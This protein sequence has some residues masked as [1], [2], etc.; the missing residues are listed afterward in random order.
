MRR[1]SLV[2]VVCALLVAVLVPVLCY[3]IYV[4]DALGKQYVSVSFLPVFH[5]YVYGTETPW[6][7]IFQGRT[8][9][10]TSYVSLKINVTNSYF[11][12][13]HI[14]YN[15][16]DVVW[17]IYNRTVSDP[18]DVVSNRNFLVW[19]ACVHTLFAYHPGSN[20]GV[21]DFTRGGFEYYSDNREL[22]NFT[23][24]IQAGAYLKGEILFYD[25]TTTPGHWRGQYWSN[26]DLHVPLGTYYMYCII[27]GIQSGPQNITVTS[28]P[29]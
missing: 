9:D 7:V 28:I 26:W 22:S 12:P 3:F 20:G 25:G 24:T 21:Y 15:G 29:W 17:L 8:M 19:G 10:Y 14:K 18:S 11:V 2:I 4:P 1:K 5:S 27:F 16:F 23:A 6:E 13:V